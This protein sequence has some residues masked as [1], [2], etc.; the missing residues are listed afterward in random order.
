MVDGYSKKGIYG[1]FKSYESMLLA[2]LACCM[3]SISALC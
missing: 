1:A 2:R 3:R